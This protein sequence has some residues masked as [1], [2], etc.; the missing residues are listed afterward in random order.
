MKEEKYTCDIEE[1]KSECSNKSLPTINQVSIQVIFTTDQ[2]EGRSCS[3]Y[4]DM[5]KVDICKS[6]MAKVLQGNYIWAHGANGYNS[7]YF[8]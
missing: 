5:K 1:C 4:L 7:Y 3:P 6:C 8:K 2:T